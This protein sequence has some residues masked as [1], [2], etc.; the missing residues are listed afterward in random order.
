MNPIRYREESILDWRSVFTNRALKIQVRHPHENATRWLQRKS[1][2]NTCILRPCWLFCPGRTGWQMDNKLCLKN[3][4]AERI[5]VPSNPRNF[6]CYC[7]HL[8]HSK[9]Y[10]AKKKFNSKIKDDCWK[11]KVKTPRPVCGDLFHTLSV[12]RLRR[13]LVIFC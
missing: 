1:L 7:M 12:F 4:N 13:L 5:N 3:P 8:T 9:N 11:R 10:W 6:W 2:T